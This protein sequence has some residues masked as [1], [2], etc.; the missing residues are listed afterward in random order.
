RIETHDD[1]RVIDEVGSF[2]YGQDEEAAE[3][4]VMNRVS[5]LWERYINEGR[6]SVDDLLAG[7]GGRW[8]REIKTRFL[9][10]VDGVERQETPA[11]WSFTKNGEFKQPNLMQRYAAWAVRVRRRVGNWSGAGAGKTL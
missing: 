3:Y 8:F 4:L 10:E 5:R 7:D 6:A 2:Y 11:G 9:A 1:L